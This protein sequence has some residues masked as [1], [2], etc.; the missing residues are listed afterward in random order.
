MIK[1]N[2]TNRAV[3]VVVIALSAFVYVFRNRTSSTPSTTS[4]VP[5]V[6]YE[7]VPETVVSDQ[8][9]GMYIEEYSPDYLSINEGQKTV[10][11]FYANWCPTCRPV[12]KE[13]K[14]KANLLPKDT[15][16]IR[17]NYNDDQVDATEKALA[18][19][20]NITYQHTFVLIDN[21]G[22]E[23]KKWNGGSLSDIISNT[24]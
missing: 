20:Y 2:M 17:V 5:A 14:Q 19:K 1:F 9:G 12:D 8:Q 13:L 11:F 10:L 4:A 18:E 21:K 23:I 7:N 22:N 24:N 6:G 15:V 3:L 16:V